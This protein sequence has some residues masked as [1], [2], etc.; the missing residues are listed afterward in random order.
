MSIKTKLA[1]F[2]IDGTIAEK[3]IVPKSVIEGIEH[4]HKKGYIT[5]VSTGR[6]YTRLKEALGDAFDTVISP[7]ALIIVE[8]GTKIVDREG[9][10]HFG[11][12]FNEREI[13]HITDFTRSN[14]D[15][16]RLAWYNPIDVSRKVQVWCVDERHVQEETE[17]RGHYA[18]VTTSSIGEFEERLLKEKLTNVTLRLKDFIKVDNLKLAFT[19]TDTN[20]IFQDSNME[21]VKNN[22]NKGL[23]VDYV[24][25]HLKIPK[26]NLLIA[27]NA[28]NDVE[29]LDMGAGI[30]VLVGPPE[31]RAAILPY[32]SQPENVHTVDSPLE[33]GHF[34]K[35][36]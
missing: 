1:L 30:V 16:F 12:Y 9:K 17:K 11:E 28:I 34:L 15:L 26:D 6:G 36:L 20:I 13:D 35:T 7:E 23:A 24:A 19:R 22:T 21:F 14:I 27:G 32:L 10:V 25:R 5:T 2:D 4:L 31:T 29:M 8:H 33:F 18:E 3:G